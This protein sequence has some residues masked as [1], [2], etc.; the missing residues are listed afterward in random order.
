M[1]YNMRKT[2]GPR[3][4]QIRENVYWSF[5]EIN[6]SRI[7]EEKKILMCHKVVSRYSAGIKIENLSNS[8]LIACFYTS[9]GLSFALVFCCAVETISDGRSAHSSLPETINSCVPKANERYVSTFRICD[10]VALSLFSANF[11]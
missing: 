8:P 10:R 4:V 6:G 3:A 1:T 7:A 5:G 9:L 2:L 11:I